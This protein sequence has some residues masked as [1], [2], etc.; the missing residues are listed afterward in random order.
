MRLMEATQPTTRSVAVRGSL[1]ALAV[2]GVIG[3]I[4]LGVALL[5]GV[6][7]GQAVQAALTLGVGYLLLN[8]T[9][10]AV[11]LPFK[12]S[13]SWAVGAALATPVV[14]SAIGFGYVAFRA[15]PQ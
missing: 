13:A 15:V 1:I 11:G 6:P 4:V 10:L 7:S 8:L 14:L 5:T 3:L 12:P 9:I 2:A